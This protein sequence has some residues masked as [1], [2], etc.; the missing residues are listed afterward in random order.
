[1]TNL[2]DI[3]QASYTA[4]DAVSDEMVE[5][6][7]EAYQ[8]CFSPNECQHDDMRRALTAALSSAPSFKVKELVWSDGSVTNPVMSPSL[9]SGIYEI[10][11][12]AEN[13]R[14]YIDLRDMTMEEAKA[15]AQADA[16]RRKAAVLSSIPSPEAL[17]REA[18]GKAFAALTALE[19]A[20]YLADI[21]EPTAKL[22]QDAITS[23]RALQA[24]QPESDLATTIAEVVKEESLGGA[25][26]GWKSCTGCLETSDGYHC[27]T[28][29]YSDTFKTH[30]GPGC[31]ECGG[32][33][34]VWE[35]YSKEA[36]E[37]MQREPEPAVKVDEWQPIETA[38][39]DWSDVLLFDAALKIDHRKVY[40]GYYD[41]EFSEWHSPAA[42]V[43][44]PTH[45]MPLPAAPLTRIGGAE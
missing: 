41:T 44:S 15:A 34:V 32:L 9:F 13:C 12:S 4:P 35:H 25:A 10:A 36:L 45:W 19:D 6:A 21:Y 2:K 1:M 33:G 42:G 29:P 20:G 40:E 38:P 17:L 7:L 37:D 22:A 26:C 30:V 18:L 31:S 11:G 3:E 5:A 39:R 8:P 23:I 16:N 28:Y 24:T 43:T 14:L 27:G